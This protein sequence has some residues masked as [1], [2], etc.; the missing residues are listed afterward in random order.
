VEEPLKV[1]LLVNTLDTGGLEGVVAQL[2]RS[3]PAVAVESFVICC[4]GGGAIADRLREEGIRV[5]LAEGQVARV[6]RILARERPALVHS[7]LATLPFLQATAQHAIPLVE[8]IHNTYVWF[9]PQEWEQE[10]ERS[11]YFSSATAV[12]SLVKA[13][14]QRWNPT[15]PGAQITV[16][17]NIVSN[18]RL[19]LIE[20]QQ[21]RQMLGF[22]DQDFVFLSLAR[23]E[24]QKNQLGMLTAFEQVAKLHSEARLL[25]AGK[26]GDL[27]YFDAVQ[28]YRSGLLG[29]ERIQLHGFREDTGVLLSAAD[30]FLLNSY[31][32]GWSL[33]ATEALLAGLPLVHSDCGS[34]RE[35]V[36]VLNENGLLVPNPAGDPLELDREIVFGGVWDRQQAN[37]EALVEAMRHMLARRADWERQRQDIRRR[38]LANNKTRQ[39]SSL[40]REFYRQSLIINRGDGNSMPP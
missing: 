22:E 1:C 39:F 20:R 12:S 13:Y 29:R 15:F 35:L 9:G 16:V 28:S 34:G 37:T 38:A 32:E 33:A 2:A 27:A 17:R 4:H 40:M 21:A 14:Y 11:R 5:Y 30:V 7:H 31:F 6:A 23:Y 10:Q 25:C 24:M 18:S 19:K 8:T 26:P 36:G 3:L